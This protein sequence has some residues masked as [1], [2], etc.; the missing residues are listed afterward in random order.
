[1]ELDL[2]ARSRII[3]AM[4][5][6]EIRR[7]SKHSDQDRTAM[8]EAVLREGMPSGWR[9]QLYPATGAEPPEFLLI[10]V[11]AAP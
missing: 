4:L 1:M 7:R 9:Y 10:P 3:M 6:A 11:S 5:R 8:V 2:W